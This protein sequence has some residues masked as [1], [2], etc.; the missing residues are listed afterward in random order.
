M[1]VP[2]GAACRAK[3]PGLVRESGT[4]LPGPRCSRPWAQLVLC[5]PVLQRYREEPGVARP[6]CS[7][8]W[9]ATLQSFV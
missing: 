5:W 1:P 4:A 3:G 9:T 7:R 8:P 2:R 6:S